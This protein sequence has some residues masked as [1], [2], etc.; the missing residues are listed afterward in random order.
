MFF[1]HERPPTQ[2]NSSPRLSPVTSRPGPGPGPAPAGEPPPPPPP[3]RA[4]DGAPAPEGGPGVH[5]SAADEEPGGVPAGVRAGPGRGAVRGV[6][7][8]GGRVQ[9]DQ[10]GLLPDRQDGPPRQGGLRRG[11]PR[12]ARRVPGPEG[13]RR[14]RPHRHLPARRGPEE[15]AQ[16]GAQEAQGAQEGQ[17]GARGGGGARGAPVRDLVQRPLR[18]L[19][20]PADPLLGRLRGGRGGGGPD[21]EARAPVRPPSLPATAPSRP[22]P[23]ARP[24]RG[25]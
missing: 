15:G 13:P 7:E 6:R 5:G 11:L 19:R 12:A 18:W 14:R 24:V 3:P 25:P 1:H 9:A 21:G 2:Q 20:G 8:P 10:A 22:V 23:A 4:R 16:E 17:G